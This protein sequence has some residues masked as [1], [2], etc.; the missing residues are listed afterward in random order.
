MLV[1]FVG[2]VADHVGPEHLAEVVAVDQVVPAVEIAATA[3][4]EGLEWIGLVHR[5]G[6]AEAESTA[7]GK[8]GLVE[9]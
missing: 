7:V 9:V 6:T 4:A 5:P 1:D 8:A 2:Q 3:E